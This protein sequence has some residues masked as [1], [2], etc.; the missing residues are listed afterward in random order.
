ML[1]KTHLNIN[2]LYNIG[3]KWST[4]I[5][6]HTWKVGGNTSTNIRDV[7]PPSAYTNEITSPA[8]GTTYDAKV[9]LMY[10]SDYGFAAVPSSWNTSMY[11]YNNSS[12]TNVNWMYIGLTEW[13]IMRSTNDSTTAFLVHEIGRINTS[14]VYNSNPTNSSNAIRPVFYLESSVMYAGGAGTISSPILI[15]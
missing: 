13:T 12:V 15:S 2:F 11:Y 4:K 14:F 7:L 10:V 9:G 6:N 8:E 3:S 1:N 5:A